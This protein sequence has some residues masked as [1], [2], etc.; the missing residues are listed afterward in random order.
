MQRRFTRRLTGFRSLSYDE[1]LHQ[2]RL[3]TLEE[4][5]NRAD[6]IYIEV[7]M[8]HGLTAISLNEMFHLDTSRRTRG[9]S[10]KVIKV[11]M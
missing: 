10:L 2:L 5:R 8:A 11:S 3:W 4:R 1:R 7:F 6:L 9:H